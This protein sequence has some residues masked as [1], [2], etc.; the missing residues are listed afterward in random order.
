MSKISINKILF[1][2]VFLLCLSACQDRTINRE[3]WPKP[4]IDPLK[5]KNCQIIKL[6][7]EEKKKYCG[8]ACW[9]EQ[10]RRTYRC[11]DGIR[12]IIE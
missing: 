6:E 9:K 7:I 8:K 2:F 4:E 3:V 12:E 10:I 11:D 5:A 1:G